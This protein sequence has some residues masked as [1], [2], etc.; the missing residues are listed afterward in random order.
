MA[1][2]RINKY[3]LLYIKAIAVILMVALHTFAF[4][5][6]IKGTG[7]KSFLIINNLP[8]EYYLFKAG[9]ICVGIFTFLS[10]YGIYIKYGSEFSIKNICNRLR[11]FFVN[12]WII[13]IIFIGIGILKGVY[14]FNLIKLST[15]LIGN[16]DVYNAEWWYIR[17][18][19]MLIIMYPI[20]V[21]IINKV[22]YKIILFISFTVNI[23]G[24]IF[25]K[26]GYIIGINSFIYNNISILLGGQFLFI[27]GIIVCKN[28]L[29]EK[30]DQKLK[31]THNK[32]LYGCIILFFIMAIINFIPILGEVLKI[33]I[34]PVFIL[35][36]T[37]IN[38][39]SKLLFIIGKHSTNI[40]LIHSFFCYYLFQDIAFY[41]KWSLLVLS[42]I[43]ILC[44]LCS[45]I[46]NKIKKIL[47]IFKK[48]FDT[49]K[50][51]YINNISQNI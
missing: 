32:G 2:N 24:M 33:L 5:E 28:K 26:L 20:I 49:I 4:P 7:F 15:G 50:L 43:I 34:T 23:L 51:T 3:N 46:I 44:I 18:Y 39:K 1:Y 40:W 48:P 19:T 37:S 11:K 42:W 10:G 31:L 41:P 17:L 13:F 16:A 6:R 27:L 14:S 30:Y 29:F 22:N 9:G 35:F 25:T 47:L 38:F 21:N 8:I 12:Y 45:I 36:L